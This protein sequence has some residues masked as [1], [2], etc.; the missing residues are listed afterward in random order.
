L[1]GPS[2]FLSR[3]GG[4]SGNSTTATMWIEVSQR[5]HRVK[6]ASYLLCGCCLIIRC[7]PNL[8]G[9]KKLN[10]SKNRLIGRRRGRLQTALAGKAEKILF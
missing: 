1:D 10:R 6:Q 4:I 3:Q 2:P 8:F 9:Q 5:I 7:S